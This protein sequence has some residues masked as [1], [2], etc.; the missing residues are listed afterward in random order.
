MNQNYG[1][2]KRTDMGMELPLLIISGIIV[3]ACIAWVYIN[4]VLKCPPL[5]PFKVFMALCAIGNRLPL[6]HLPDDLREL[7][8]IR[9]TNPM[10]RDW[11]NTLIRRGDITRLEY[12]CINHQVSKDI[13]TEIKRREL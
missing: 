6:D 1:E 4:L 3:Y 9:P 2:M 13:R 11:H 10:Y 8:N 5:M 7:H 12:H